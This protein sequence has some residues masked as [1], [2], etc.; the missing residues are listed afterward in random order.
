MA[1]AAALSLGAQILNAL[2]VSQPFFLTDNQQLA[3]FFNGADHSNPPRWDI[4]PITQI[5]SNIISV[6]GGRV[7][8]ID[9]KLNTTAHSLAHKAHLLDD[10]SPN[11][12]Q[13]NCN[14]PHH[15]SSCPMLTAI[16]NVLGD[17][18]TLIAGVCC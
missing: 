5:V 15:V 18:F 14:N 2:R 17:H 16:N 3:T 10:V 7:F 4:K 9:I 1:E 13:A 12:F 6:N 8:K 11:A